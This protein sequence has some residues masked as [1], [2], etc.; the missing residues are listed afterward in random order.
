MHFKYNKYYTPCPGE[1]KEI[2]N[3]MDIS[4]NA[5]QGCGLDFMVIVQYKLYTLEL[6]FRCPWHI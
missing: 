6:Q 3:G 4:G 5:L 1:R 2:A